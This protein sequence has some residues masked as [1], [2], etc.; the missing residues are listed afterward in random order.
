MLA[1][2]Q[3]ADA[4]SILLTNDHQSKID[5]VTQDHSKEKK[6]LSD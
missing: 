3:A 6:K 2:Q 4:K 5:S 1:V